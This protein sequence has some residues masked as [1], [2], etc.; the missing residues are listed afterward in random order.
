MERVAVKTLK[1]TPPYTSTRPMAT[2]VGMSRTAISRRWR[3]FRL[4]PH[5]VDGFKASPD[6]VGHYLYPRDAAVLL[7]ADGNCQV[8]ASVRPL[9]IGAQARCS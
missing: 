4:E 1:R 7:C 5:L 3:A 9:C 6:L 2:A 8:Q